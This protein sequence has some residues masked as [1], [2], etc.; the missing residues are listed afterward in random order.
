MKALS[1]LIVRYQQDE[2]RLTKGIPVP[3]MPPELVEILAAGGHV[4]QIKQ[5]KKEGK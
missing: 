2:Y 3:E 4:E 5:V 1:D